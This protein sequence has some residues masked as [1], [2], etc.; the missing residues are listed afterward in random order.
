[1][2]VALVL[3]QGCGKNANDQSDNA[4]QDDTNAVGDQTSTEP[5]HDEA[6]EHDDADEHGEADAHGDADEHDEGDEHAEAGGHAEADEQDEHAEGDAHGEEAEFTEPHTYTEA[7]HVIHGQLEKISSLM[8]SGALDRVHAEAAVIR[9]VA[10]TLAKFALE[11]SEI[12]RDAIK[13]INL[14][15]RDLAATFGPIDEAG[16]SGDLDGTQKVYDEMIKLLE[17]LEKYANDGNGGG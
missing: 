4:D 6:D 15:A 8:E 13:E 3:F 12:P 16:D 14:A 7:I 5:D 11:D 2:V 9:D 10:N 1:M 17:T